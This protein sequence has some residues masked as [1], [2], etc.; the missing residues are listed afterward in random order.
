MRPEA[1]IAAAIEVLDTVLD[2]AATEAALTR[3]ARASRFAG[4]KD[5]AA[6][7]DHVFDAVRNLRSYAWLGGQQWPGTSGRAVMLGALRA[8]RGDPAEMFTGQGHAPAALT[9]DEGAPRGE[10]PEQERWN[11]PDWLV[12]V[13]ENSLAEDAR[14]CAALLSQRAPVTIRVNRAKTDVAALIRA[15]L[16][17]EVTAVPNPIS[18]NA[19]TVTAGARKL[20]RLAAFDDGLFEMQDAS[21][22]AVIGSLELRAGSRVLDFCAGGGGKSLA[23]AAHTGT[24]VW[25]HDV[26]AARMS[27]IP[28]R[29]RRAGADIRCVRTSQLQG[30][31]FDCVL[32]DAPCSGSGSWR[33]APD[34]KW[35]F[36]P[37]RLA[38]LVQLQSEILQQA[39]A[40]VAPGGTL[41]YATCSVLE[42]ENGAQVGRFI[43]AHPQWSVAAQTSWPISEQGDGF[44]LSQLK[45][46]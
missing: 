46:E 41:A 39:A 35:R 2:G 19:L 29:A 42:D 44:F 16:T 43:G 11:L 37:K 32:V 28:E 1:R 17:D 20:T 10:M 23:I 9:P 6:V 8:G 22:Q 13:F 21:S 25:A 38:E 31:Q 14:S 15:L 33:R 12:P 7:R 5:R 3:W 34:A 18:D 27:D 30:Q 4:S 36:T 24:Q 45:R 26:D 40:Y